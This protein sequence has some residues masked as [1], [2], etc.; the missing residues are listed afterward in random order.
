MYAVCSDIMLD[1]EQPKK[2]MAIIGSGIAGLSTAELLADTFD[3]ILI[4]SS[5]NIGM[6]AEGI[7]VGHEYCDD[8]VIHKC[9]HE[10]REPN[11]RIDVPLRVFSEA[12]YPN[13]VGLYNTLGIQFQPEN[14]ETSFSFVGLQA[15]FSY[16]NFI[17]RSLSLPFVK[18]WPIADISLFSLSFWRI[19]FDW[20]CFLFIA[21]KDLSTSILSPFPDSPTSQ[22]TLEEYLIWRNFSNEFI[23]KFIL[24]ACASMATCSLHSAANYP[25]WAMVHYM[26]TRSW[27]GVRRVKGGAQEVCSKIKQ[28][29]KKVMVGCPVTKIELDDRKIHVHYI[30]RKKKI[31]EVINSVL[32]PVKIARELFCEMDV[33]ESTGEPGVE[34]VD[35]V[36]IASQANIAAKLLPENTTDDRLLALRNCLANIKY[37]RSQLIVHVDE[38]LM[39]SRRQDWRSVN[40]IL[41]SPPSS[42][43]C[44]LR[45]ATQIAP[46]SLSQLQT[47]GMSSIWMNKVQAGLRLDKNIFQTWNPITEPDTDKI[48]GRALFTRPVP[49]VD[50]AANLKEL[51]KHQGASNVFVVGSY[52]LHG[53]PLL[54]VGVD[55]AVRVAKMLGVDAPWVL[56]FPKDKNDK[57]MQYSGVVHTCGANQRMSLFNTLFTVLN[58]FFMFLMEF[59]MALYKDFR[60]PLNFIKRSIR[61]MREIIITLKNM[62]NS[63]KNR[64]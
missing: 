57:T 49:T 13:L 46:N 31:S 51:W 14:Y 20:L 59:S 5:F 61:F 64:Q 26:I 44:A 24:P 52:S 37:E 62:N 8:E 11:V 27:R 40:F 22:L 32:E 16:S 48:L 4:E 7:N 9:L 42:G 41:P 3:I 54:E 38:K 30:Q 47:E 55:S 58:A 34:V 39:P 15:Y 10:G 36:I 17:I 53:I 28:R 23:Y 56:K 43:K 29:C 18:M 35:M 33:H 12:Y 6:D 63:Q 50:T 2:R 1:S 45:S 21:G 25:A 60:N 19:L